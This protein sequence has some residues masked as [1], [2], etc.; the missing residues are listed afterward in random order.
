MVTKRVCPDY[1]SP[2]MTARAWLSGTVETPWHTARTAILTRAEQTITQALVRK[3]LRHPDLLRHH[4]R[5]ANGPTKTI[6]RRLEHLRGI[7]LGFGNLTGYTIRSLI[8][9]R[10]LKDHLTTTT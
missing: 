4:P 5:T 1:F 10:R 3:S 2:A 8:Y 7:A 6:N 9:A